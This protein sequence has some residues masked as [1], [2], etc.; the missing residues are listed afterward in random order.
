MKRSDCQMIVALM[1]LSVGF[2][3]WEDMT[4]FWLPHRNLRDSSTMLSSLPYSQKEIMDTAKHFTRFS[5]RLLVFD[6]TH[7]QAFSINHKDTPYSESMKRTYRYSA[8]I[9]FLIRCLRDQFPQRFQ[10]GQ[11]VFQLLF[12]DGD[13]PHSPCVNEYCPVDTFSPLLMFGSSPKNASALPTIQ[14]FPNTYFILCL[15]EYKT[16]GIHSCQWPHA[17]TNNSTSSSWE[18]LID[19]L[20]W[21]GSDYPFLEYYNEF[22]FDGPDTLMEHFRNRWRG[23]TKE[24]LL[25]ELHTSLDSRFPPRWRAVLQ[26]SMVENETTPWIDAKFVAGYHGNVYQKLADKGIHMIGQRIESQEMSKYK[27]Q[28][29]FGGGGGTS[30]EGTLLKLSM[31]GVLFHHESKLVVHVL[32]HYNHYHLRSHVFF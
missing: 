28:V 5:P 23:L 25:Q 12:H 7:F 11:P 30:W 29:D 10:P 1:V 20:V 3:G 6:G 9:P 27:Y 31:P 4:T 18:S 19:T 22:Q 21:R 15:I 32:V 2:L 13:S 8:L 14:I 16:H 24:K 26:S 17:V